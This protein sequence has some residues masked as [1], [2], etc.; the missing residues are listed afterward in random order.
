MYRL[1]NGTLTVLLVLRRSLPAAAVAAMAGA[2]GWLLLPRPFGTR[3]FAAA[4][5]APGW[6]L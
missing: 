2:E 4:A 3:C 5:A 1:P 6:G